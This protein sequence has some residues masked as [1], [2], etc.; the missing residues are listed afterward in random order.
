MGTEKGV[1]VGSGWGKWGLCRG[2]YIIYFKKVLEGK[3]AED[4]LKLTR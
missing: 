1:G 4:Q 3:L 2:S